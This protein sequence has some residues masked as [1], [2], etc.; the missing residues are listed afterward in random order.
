MTRVEFWIP[1]ISLLLAVAASADAFLQRFRKSAEKSYAAEREFNHIRNTL[2]QYSTHL[3]QLTREIAEL[4]HEI[5]E[6]RMYSGLLRRRR[7][8][9]EE[10][11]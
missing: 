5:L 4:R 3:E 2:A 9:L 6:L 11:G 1:V 10:E 8:E 7:G